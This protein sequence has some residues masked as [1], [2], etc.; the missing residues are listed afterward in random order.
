VLLV[1]FGPLT[2][3]QREEPLRP[4]A[5]LAPW[6]AAALGIGALAFVLAPQAPWKTAL[7]VAV[8]AWVLLG[9][10]RFAW[11]RVH[12]AGRR[13]TPEMLGMVLAH[14]GIGVFL[15]GALLTDAQ[16]QQRELAMTPGQSVEVAGHRFEFAGVERVQGPNYMA[17]RG[18][19]RAT[20]P[21]GR[22]HVLH[23]EKRAYA[24]GGQ[25]MTEAAIH[26]GASR[27]LYVALGESLGGDSWAVRVYVRPFVRWIWAGA[28]LMA[29]GGLVA[30][31]DRR[32]RRLPE[33]AR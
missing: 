25:V 9:T 3:W 10:L 28:A 24:A 5:M 26:A 6:F 11:T 12:A 16:L 22:T 14:A 18:T 1:P 8:A 23:P 2:R 7:G 33:G 13:F 17:D 32:F 4:L 29:L 31:S 27:D 30:A 21:R 15:V 20:S 19:I